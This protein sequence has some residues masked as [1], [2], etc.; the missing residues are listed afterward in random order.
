MFIENVQGITRASGVLTHMHTLG[1]GHLSQMGIFSITKEH[2]I[3]PRVVS[4]HE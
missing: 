3:R 1:S 4:L 2:D